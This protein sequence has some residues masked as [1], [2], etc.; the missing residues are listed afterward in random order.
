M[1]LGIEKSQRERISAGGNPSAAKPVFAAVLTA[2]FLTACSVAPILE[3]NAL[4][5][6]DTFIQSK[7]NQSTNQ[8]QALWWH[9]FQQPALNR[10]IQTALSDNNN[11]HSIAARLKAAQATARNTNAQRWPN[12]LLGIS[13]TQ[14][15]GDGN[16]GNASSSNS[17]ELSSNYGVDLWGAAR[18][19]YQ[20]S[21]YG[22]EAAKQELKA[23][24]IA[25]AGNVASL[26]FQ[27]NTSEQL[28]KLIQEERNTYNAVLELLEQ[29]FRNGQVSASDILRQRQLVASTGALEAST[30]ADLGSQK[31]ALEE[32][33]GI[34][35][36]QGSANIT[37]F[38]NSPNSSSSAI[39][40]ALP[41]TGIPA[42]VIANRP[43]VLQQWYEVK[44][45]NEDIA[46]A[47]AD[48][49]PQL[50][51]NLSYTST[52]GSALFDDWLGSLLSSL[53][54]PLFDA[55]TRSAELDRRRAVLEESLASYKATALSAFREV[56]D[57]LLQLEQ[58]QIQ[59]ENLEQQLQLSQAVAERQ[60]R[61]LRGG[62]ADF[63]AL[64][65]AQISTS[66]LKRDLLSAQQKQRDLYI[67]LRQ[68]LAGADTKVLSTNSQV[69][70]EQ[71]QISS[72]SSH[73]SNSIST[74]TSSHI[75][76]PTKD[77]L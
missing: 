76:T 8:D 7:G 16:S 27:V 39:T 3:D 22:A 29:R 9:D 66:S 15:F 68:S 37:A 71:T 67:T 20:S 21:L 45:A 58:Q 73:T 6:P 19:A 14:R 24:Q 61:Q 13:N 36:G 77:S 60:L 28:L 64:L 2:A 51:L 72:S 30:T 26:W 52:G 1:P 62:S 43:D 59:V 17:V 12:I 34:A 25:L 74:D 48:R 10:A 35:A 55:G 40:P 57:A 49:Y 33:L 38:D 42:K 4:T 47:I 53:T 65:D 63:L 31:H 56:Q 32:L 69:S 70:T 75:S 11:L 46:I 5:L 23:A 54:A 41:Q 50:G 44:A 18:S